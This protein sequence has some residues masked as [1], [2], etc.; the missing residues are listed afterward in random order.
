MSPIEITVSKEIAAPAEKIY[1]LIADYNEGHPRI[2]PKPYFVSLEVEEG[3]VG[4]GTIIN[5]QMS[6]MGQKQDFRAEISEP[7]PGRVLVETDLNTGAPTT[8]TV[9]A[10]DA[11]KSRVTISTLLKTRKG[12]VG[13]LEGWFTRRFLTPIY[14]EELTLIE[15]VAINQ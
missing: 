11:E 1:A 7:E 8:F 13:K 6:V 14:E 4:A 15:E 10:L 2:L 3:G 5:F 12:L 9:D